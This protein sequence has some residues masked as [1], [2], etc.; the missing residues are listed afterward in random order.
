MLATIR[1]GIKEVISTGYHPDGWFIWPVDHPTVKT[2]TI[3]F[4]VKIFASR[5]NCVII[6]RHADK[7]GHPIIIPAALV[8]PEQTHLN[9]LKEVIMLSGFPIHY[10][11]VDDPGILANINTPEDLRYV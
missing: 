6:P 1:Y 10:T 4:M 9:G 3:R 8:I 7:N 2:A 11:E 5:L